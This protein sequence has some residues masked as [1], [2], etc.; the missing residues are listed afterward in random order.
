M[1]MN[2]TFIQVED[3]D[4]VRFRRNPDLVEDLF[5]PDT[6]MPPVF[7]TLGK[8]MQ[9][10]VKAHGPQLMAGWLARVDPQLRERI[11]GSIGRTTQAMAGGA[12]GADLLR[13]MQ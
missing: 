2:A 7:A 9:E 11:E 13:L 4:L 1:S 10:R 8:A 5:T 6:I 12:G 3:A